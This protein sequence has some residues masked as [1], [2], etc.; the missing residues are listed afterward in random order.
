MTSEQLRDRLQELYAS[1]GWM[2]GA[3]PT[4]FEPGCVVGAPMD[5]VAPG[6]CWRIIGSATKEEFLA[7]AEL[8]GGLW[9]PPYSG[10]TFYY[11]VE[12]M[13]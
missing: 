3:S 13:D 10:P 4:R 2:C 8:A 7:Q 9:I 6:T 5:D 11:R 1:Q 12:A